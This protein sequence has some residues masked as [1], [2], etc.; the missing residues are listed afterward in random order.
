[1]KKILIFIAAFVVIAFA[2]CSRCSHKKVEPIDS[3]MVTKMIEADNAH[4]D[5][6]DTTYKY[7]ETY[8]L[9]SGTF[10]TLETPTIDSV[11]SIFQT[12]NEETLM[13][14]VYFSEHKIVNDTVSMKWTIVENAW[15][16]ED[17]NLKDFSYK[18][19]VED[20]FK[21]MKETPYEK[22]KARACV[23][24]LQLGPKRCN[25]QY[26]FG[27]ETYGMI[28]VDAIT[29]KADTINPAFGFARELKR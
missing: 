18:L 23:L 25:P 14:T 2:S 11:S 27:N 22:P 10:D 5:S 28:F 9:F 16:G 3:T 15:W 12:F 20:A 17:R 29:A 4:M 26:I 8:Y 1:M 13:S 6:I 24:R 7:F 21:I 19:T